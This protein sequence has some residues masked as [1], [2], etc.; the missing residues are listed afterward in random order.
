MQQQG[1]PL[2]VGKISG[3]FG[4][5]GWLKLT[6]YTRPRE[7]ILHYLPL[8]F[9]QDDEW[10]KLQIERTEKR[11]DRLLVKI[12]DIDTPEQARHYVNSELAI[13][14]YQLPRL[15]QGKYYWH[16][17]IGLDVYNLEGLTLGKVEEILETGAND[18]LSIRL[19]ETSAPR[20]LIPLVTDVYIKEVDL[21][22]ARIVVDWQAEG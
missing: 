21:A 3:V 8:L 7:N 9:L 17:L 13:E 4:I 2:I 5:K 6:S 1:S 10:Q 15:E 11:G 22:H 18:V 20:I 16:Q 12:A 19:P 14:T